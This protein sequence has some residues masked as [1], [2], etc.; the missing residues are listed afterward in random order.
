M[1]VL[2]SDKGF[3]YSGMSGIG[4]L[5]LDVEQAFEFHFQEFA[6]QKCNTLNEITKIHGHYFQIVEV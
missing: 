1:L 5:T 3:Y 6:A 2:K 4:F